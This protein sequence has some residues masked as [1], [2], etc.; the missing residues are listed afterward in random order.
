MKM[1]RRIKIELNEEIEIQENCEIQS[2]PWQNLW[3]AVRRFLLTILKFVVPCLFIM[4]RLT[5][6]L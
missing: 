4:L 1:Q 3:S 6:H 5:A 2:N